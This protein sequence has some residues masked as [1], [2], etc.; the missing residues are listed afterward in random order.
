MFIGNTHPATTDDGIAE[1]LKA[2]AS[3]L[4]GDEALDEELE[5]LEVECL[6]RPR[7]GGQPLRSK[8]WRVK[9]PN[10]FREHMKKPEAF[11]MGWSSRRFFPARSKSTVAELN[12]SKKPH[13]EVTNGQ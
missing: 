6:T 2:C 8:Q 1:I 4:T 7:Q 10:R 12:P 5:V 9:V 11:P 13:L 3:D